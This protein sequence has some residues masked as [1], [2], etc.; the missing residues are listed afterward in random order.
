MAIVL[1]GLALVA[2]VVGVCWVAAE[3]KCL[4]NIPEEIWL[5]PAAIGGVFVGALIPFSIHKRE[6]SHSHEPHLVCAKEAIFGAACL[7]VAAVATGVIGAVVGNLLALCGVG[8]A[9]GGVF[10]GLFIPSPGRRDP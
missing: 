10:F 6:N 9:L 1:L 7:V 4:R 5:L 2:A 8:T 3:H